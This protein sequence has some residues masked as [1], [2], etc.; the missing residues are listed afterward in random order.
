MWKDY[1]GARCRVYGVDIQ[2]SCKAYE[3][4]HVRIFIGDQQ[5]RNFWIA[6]KKEVPALDI[7]VDDGG[8]QFEQQIASLEELLPHLRPGGVYLCEDVHSAFNRFAFYVSG[9]IHGL[10]VGKI[11]NKPH[12]QE[13]AQVLTTSGFQS[14]IDSMHFYPFIAVLKKRDTRVSELASRKRGTQW[15]PWDPMRV[16]HT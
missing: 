3:D 2:E 8:H 14:M 12:D 1:F 7:V 4:E 9:M 15:Q 11:A 5:D 16:G 6:F 10:N 13:R